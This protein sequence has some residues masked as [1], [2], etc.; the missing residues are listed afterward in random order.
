MTHKSL[1]HA[2]L[3]I[4]QPSHSSHPLA[5]HSTVKRQIAFP[6]HIASY[7]HPCVLARSA[8]NLKFTGKVETLECLCLLY[9][10]ILFIFQQINQLTNM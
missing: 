3:D 7:L 6:H 8:L 10:I 1:V 9:L 2:K 4:S 5:L